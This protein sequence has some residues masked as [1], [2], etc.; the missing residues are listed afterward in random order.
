[1]KITKETPNLMVIKDYSILSFLVGLVFVSTGS[2]LLFFV[3]GREE[4]IKRLIGIL[5]FLA[6]LAIVLSV[7][8]YT[9]LID[10]NL[11]K[12]FVISKKIVGY[13]SKKQECDLSQIKQ[14]EFHISHDQEQL[15]FILKDGR[16]FLI[17]AGGITRGVG[18]KTSNNEKIGKRICNF[19]DISFIRVRTKSLTETL[20]TVREIIREGPKEKNK[21]RRNNNTNL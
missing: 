9:I 17:P 8:T 3:P 4:L 7:K 6:G 18:K 13:K 5:H 21:N 14:L 19:L 20:S 12:L 10:K 11:N 16:D 15:L 1:M 2:Y